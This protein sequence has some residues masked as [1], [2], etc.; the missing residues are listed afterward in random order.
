MILKRWSH[1]SENPISSVSILDSIKSAEAP[2]QYRISP[3]GLNGE[4]S[5]PNSLV[6]RLSTK[7]V[8]FGLFGYSPSFD[9]TT[10]GAMMAAQIGWYFINGNPNDFD[11]EPVDESYRFLNISHSGR[12]D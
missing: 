2:G 8:W 9:P 3:N 4:R 6:F 7:Q 12:V 10:T 5:L 11:E 1:C